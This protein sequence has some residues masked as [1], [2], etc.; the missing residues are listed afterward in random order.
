MNQDHSS[1]EIRFDPNDLAGMIALMD[2]YGDSTT[3]FPGTNDN[4]ETVHISIYH[5]RIVVS[6]M[7]DN[8]WNRI[9][10]YWRDGTREETFDGK[11]K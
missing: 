8:G 9:N 7:Q 3:M 11:W 6:T 5:E 4:G 10:T 2:A 1:Q